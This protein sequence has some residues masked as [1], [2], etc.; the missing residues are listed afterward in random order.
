M[1]NLDNTPLAER[2]RLAILDAI[3]KR[4]FEHD[5]LPAE[6]EL[7]K[8]LNISRTTIRTA[9]HSL[10][11][12]GIITRRRAIGTTVNRHVGPATLA[13]QRLIPFD[14]LLEDSGYKTRAE[15]SWHRGPVPADLAKAFDLEPGEVCYISEK[16]FYANDELAIYDRGVVPERH[17]E[18][19]LP[20]DAP[21]SLSD[22]SQQHMTAAIDHSVTAIVPLTKRRG[23]STKL[24]LASGTPFLRLHERHYSRTGQPIAYSSLDVDDSFVRFEVFRHK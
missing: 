6:G 24:E 21:S 10:E 3:L 19:E 17:L 9:L 15:V 18:G 11:Q 16:L 12:D 20:E 4:Q 5:R 8:M 23:T 14:A 2:A 7:A 13:L 22:F 1:D